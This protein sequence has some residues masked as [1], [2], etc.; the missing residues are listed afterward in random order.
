LE[1]SIVALSAIIGALT[2]LPGYSKHRRRRSLL[3]F[4]AG[5]ALILIA[6]LALGRS[7]QFELPAVLCGA[8]MIAIGHALNRRLC[9]SCPDCR[10]QR[11]ESN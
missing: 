3:L 11:A 8:C 4:S 2:L 10:Q 9:G 7:P 5:L 1:W 6:R